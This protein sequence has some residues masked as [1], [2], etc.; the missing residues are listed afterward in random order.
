MSSVCWDSVLPVEPLHFSSTSRDPVVPWHFTR[1][2]GDPVVPV[3]F[4]CTLGEPVVTVRISNTSGDPVV[5]FTRT[6]GDPVVPGH[7]SSTSWDTVLPGHVSGTSS[8]PVVT[9]PPLAAEEVQCQLSE[10]DRMIRSS[11]QQEGGEARRHPH[12]LQGL[13]G[14]LLCGGRQGERAAQPH[15]HV[16]HLGQGAQQVEKNSMVFY[17]LALVLHGPLKL[18]LVVAF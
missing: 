4:S 8:D 11:V 12:V 17:S 5:H 10:G 15:R 14:L 13:C 7:F 6:S 2:S 3:H 18:L 1:T 16:H 9:S